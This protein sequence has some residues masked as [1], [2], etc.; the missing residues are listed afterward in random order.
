MEDDGAGILSRNLPNLITA[1][2][3]AAT[4]LVAWLLL[5]PEAESR[6]LAFGL[7][8]VAALSDLWDGYL[9][10]RRGLITTFGKLVDPVADK[11]L[12]VATL[13]PLYVITT[14]GLPLAELPLFGVVPLWVVLVL[15]GRE[16][17][18]TILRVV[19]ARRGKVVPARNIGKRK[20]VAQN[21]F[22]GAGILWVAFRTP[23]FSVPQGAAW[24]TFERFHAWFTT[25]FLTVAL[26]LTVVSLAIYLRAFSRIFVGSTG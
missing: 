20:T 24:S 10:R 18:V 11:L 15:L 3:V 8:V 1:G 2:R 25:A 6:F 5:R 9:A 17:L 7:F 23:G 12:L 21:I 26:V 19:A 14:R 13:V 22:I 16:A 4:P